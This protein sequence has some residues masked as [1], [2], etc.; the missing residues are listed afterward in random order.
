MARAHC[1]ALAATTHLGIAAPFGRI[2]ATP[3]LLAASRSRRVL[4]PHRSSDMRH[5]QLR[6]LRLCTFF[7][8][9]L[10]ALHIEVQSRQN[11]N[12]VNL[13]F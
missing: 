3:P 12:C 6:F 1:D 7:S 10:T 5:V 9:N 4:G 2:M 11:R 8:N 13:R